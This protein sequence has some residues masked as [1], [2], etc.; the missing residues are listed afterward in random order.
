MA[1]DFVGLNGLQTLDLSNNAI[2]ALSSGAFS[3]LA[4]LQT[5]YLGSNPLS[6]I[7]FSAFSGLS[8]VSTLDLSA[9]QLSSISSSTFQG[10]FGVRNLNLA[11]NY[12]GSLSANLFS[13]TTALTTL[14]LQGNNIGALV[15]QAFTGL[16]ALRTLNLRGNAVGA[17][18]AQAFIGLSSL[19]TLD[20]GINLLSG[21]GDLQFSGLAALKNLYLDGNSILSIT[22]QAFQG[23]PVLQ[24]LNLASNALN[25]LPETVFLGHPNLVDL[26][27]SNNGLSTFYLNTFLN[28]PALEI[29]DLH[30]NN[31][32]AFTNALL[33]G[34]NTLQEIYLQSNSLTIVNGTFSGLSGLEIIDISGNHITSVSAN[35]FLN[36]VALQVI[37]INDNSISSLPNNIFSTLSALRV[38]DLSSNYLTVLNSSLLLGSANLV[39]FYAR[40]NVLTSLTGPLISSSL[41]Q[42]FDVQNNFVLGVSQGFFSPLI[43]GLEVLS[44]HGNPSICH[45]GFD[46][47]FQKTIY[48][49]CGPGFVSLQNDACANVYAVAILDLPSVV[50]AGQMYTINVPVSILLSTTCGSIVGGVLTATSTASSCTFSNASTVFWTSSVV[51]AANLF[52]PAFEIS[53]QSVS[54]TTGA[55]FH[56]Q[57]PQPEDAL[58][59]SAEAS[60]FVYVASSPLPQGLVLSPRAGIISGTVVQATASQSIT[61]SLQDTLSLL[62]QPVFV[63]TMTVNNPV[64]SKSSPVS[65]AAYVVPIVMAFVIAIGVWLY[66]RYERRKLFH[67]F[68]SYREETEAKLA[69]TLNEKLQ[70]YFLSTG[71]RVRVFLDK[72]DLSN[73]GNKNVVIR[74]AI[75]HTCLFL[76]LMSDISLEFMK[77]LTPASPPDKFLS[78][79]EHAVKFS[80]KKTVVICPVLVGAM[81]KKG[82]YARFDTS[83]LRLQGFPQRPSPTSPDMV[84]D[85]LSYVL[86]IQGVLLEESSPSTENIAAIVKCLDTRAWNPPGKNAIKMCKRWF[87]PKESPTFLYDSKQENASDEDMNAGVLDPLNLEIIDSAA[88]FAFPWLQDIL[89][90]RES[91]WND[92]SPNSLRGKKLLREHLKQLQLLRGFVEEC[93]ARPDDVP[94]EQPSWATPVPSSSRT[95]PAPSPRMVPKHL[96]SSKMNNKIGPDQAVIMIPTTPRTRKGSVLA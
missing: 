34:L 52:N 44:M 94:Q 3:G 55:T 91:M 23:L 65:P 33:A 49:A 45:L 54:L 22:S 95:S 43:N 19:S 5:L 53:F 74:D 38:I 80:R 51:T 56:V 66:I 76:P 75:K 21:L 15:P 78:E 6:S 1:A 30:G 39:E 50:S 48:C 24:T 2:Q 31:L 88:K 58:V 32:V 29:I 42:I 27:L 73:P 9:C 61:V 13:I 47:T 37:R 96:S 68:I 90:A 12:I 69:E 85:T 82:G 71:H 72:Q 10:L 86:N 70:H 4:S 18:Y 41:L 77:G 8:V 64:V 57:V 60:R 81:N 62:S 46:L 40:S 20:L 84:K 67:I 14:N 36:C 83:V 89:A 11:F 35:A 63:L 87:R 28:A 26:D 25:Y 17:I 79:L 59:T 16:S 7:G 93:R 92:D